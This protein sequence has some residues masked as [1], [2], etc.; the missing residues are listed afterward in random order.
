LKALIDLIDGV[1]EQAVTP[2]P[3]QQHS[4]AALGITGSVRERLHG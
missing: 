2:V 3:V 4:A 1:A